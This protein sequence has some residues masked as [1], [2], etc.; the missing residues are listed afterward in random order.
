MMETVLTQLYNEIYR[1]RMN[2]K[3]SMSLTEIMI[4]I[5][6]LLPK[7]KEQLKDAFNAGSASE[8]RGL[9]GQP[10]DFQEYQSTLSQTIYYD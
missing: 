5:H 10:K 1:E 4:K 7:E 6:R 9:M 2:G 3:V 8:I